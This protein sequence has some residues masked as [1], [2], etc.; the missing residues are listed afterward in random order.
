[1]HVSYDGFLLLWL[2]SGEWSGGE[3]EVLCYIEERNKEMCYWLLVAVHS[4]SDGQTAL[5]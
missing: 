3:S 4:T 1:M 5:Q 2:C